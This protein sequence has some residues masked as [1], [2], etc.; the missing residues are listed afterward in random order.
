MYCTG[1]KKLKT[2][3]TIMKH[4]I[5]YMALLNWIGLRNCFS[6]MFCLNFLEE[7]I[8][9]NDPRACFD[10]QSWTAPPPNSQFVEMSNLLMFSLNQ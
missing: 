2:A 9:E 7:T 4:L 10:N 8:C 1:E 5:V 3:P 6:I